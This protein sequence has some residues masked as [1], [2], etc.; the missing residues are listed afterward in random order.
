M[1]FLNGES[2]FA[3]FVPLYLLY[4]CYDNKSIRLD[5]FAEDSDRVFDIE[6]QIASH[7]SLPLRMRYYQSL[8]D[9][10]S[11]LKGD[12]YENFLTL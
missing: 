10:D 9:V 3:V 1:R 7:K 8:M 11:L 6:I 4:P 12:M 5:V 2:F